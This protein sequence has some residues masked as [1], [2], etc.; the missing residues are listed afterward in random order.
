MPMPAEI[1]SIAANKSQ[2][3]TLNPS[4]DRAIFDFKENYLFSAHAQ[5]KYYYAILFSHNTHKNTDTN[6]VYNHLDLTV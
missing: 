3:Q 2:S 1:S 5:I 6:K 4:L